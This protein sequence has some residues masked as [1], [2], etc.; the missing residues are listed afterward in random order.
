MRKIMMITKHFP[1]EI[2]AASNRAYHI[3]DHLEKKDYRIYIITSVPAYPNKKIYRDTEQKLSLNAAIYRLPSFGWFGFQF[4][5]RF[6]NP[7]IFMMMSIIVAVYLRFKHSVKTVITTSPPLVINI[8][9]ILLKRVFNIKWIVEVRDLW[10]E[11]LVAIN[12][13]YKTR[14]LFKILQTISDISYKAS[15]RI[16]TVTHSAKQILISK[17]YSSNKISVVT[18]GV[19][20]WAIQSAKIS[21]KESTDKDPSRDVFHISYIGNIGMAQDFKLLIQVAEQLKHRR[22]I[23]FNFI[24]EGIQRNKLQLMKEQLQLDNVHIF[25]GVIDRKKLID[26]YLMTDVALITLKKSKFF[27]TVIPSKL[28]ECGSLKVPVVF[29]GDGE[30][31]DLIRK[32]R[33]GIVSEHRANDVV[34]AIL[35]LISTDGHRETNDAVYDKFMQSF[36]WKHLIEEYDRMLSDLCDIV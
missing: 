22:D 18:N 15:D 35:D 21:L 23:Q 32:Y 12:P 2:G 5:E 1:P 17:G 9:G 25:E 11:S 13:E 33:L 7:I 16:V 8:A 24:G 14:I 26:R 6:F 10:P 36:N 29:I 19:P 20:D 4:A 28:F 30:A 34:K 31:A 27:E 3:A